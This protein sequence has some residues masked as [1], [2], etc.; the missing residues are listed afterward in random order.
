MLCITQQQRRTDPQNEQL[1]FCILP[2]LLVVL[3]HIEGVMWAAII[4]A[5]YQPVHTLR[6]LLMKVK[7]VAINREQEVP[8]SHY[9]CSFIHSVRNTTPFPLI[10]EP[11]IVYFILWSL[12]LP[13]KVDGGYVF[14]TVSLCEQDM[15]K[16]YG[17]IWTKSGGQV[18]C[19]TMTNWLN[20]VKIWI[21]KREIKIYCCG[22]PP[23]GVRAAAFS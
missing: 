22:S 21:R 3:E 17:Q 1:D 4:K 9:F 7:D 14:I 20:L 19:V 11:S 2:H 10:A 15:S 6:W 18:A 12:P 8:T 13:P 5:V 16:T 23:V